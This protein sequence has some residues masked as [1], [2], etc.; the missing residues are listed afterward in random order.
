MMAIGSRR[1]AAVDVVVRGVAA[2]RLTREA[3]TSVA[4]M[5]AG[6]IV[7]MFVMIGLTERVTGVTAA[8]VMELRQPQM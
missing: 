1:V 3:A 8:V 6:T 5:T 4:L 2:L 7:M